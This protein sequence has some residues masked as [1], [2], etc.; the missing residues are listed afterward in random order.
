MRVE[1]ALF[2]AW[3]AAI[4]AA[5]NNE[6]APVVPENPPSGDLPPP[7]ATMTTGPAMVVN[8]PAEDASAPPGPAKESPVVARLDPTRTLP[9]I[10][11]GCGVSSKKLDPNK[12]GCN[13]TAPATAACNTITVPHHEGGC[14][15]EDERD[16]CN[17]L[18][19]TFKSRIAQAASQCSVARAKK[20]N[21]DAC[22]HQQCIFD[23]LVTACPD[24]AA[25]AACAKIETSCK[26]YDANVCRTYLT[27]L[28]DR[29]RDD[30]VK[31]LQADCSKGYY[32]CV[33]AK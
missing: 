31:C 15:E 1:R 9:G 20:D 4:A 23:A 3:T 12:K 29:G 11:T 28:T 10:E 16:F 21:C 2:L 27:G 26:G 8:V 7:P 33:V 19:A 18:R 32:T 13:D 17:E 30:A 22:D 25:D 5:C 24:T 14:D 6:P